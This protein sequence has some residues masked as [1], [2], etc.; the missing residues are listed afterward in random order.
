MGTEVLIGLAVRAAL[1]QAVRIYQQTG[2]EMS[3]ADFVAAADDNLRTAQ[4][5]YGSMKA[6]LA[7]EIERRRAEE[8][9]RT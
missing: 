2:Q 4:T 7:A 3:V 6:D 9:Q 5:A 8:E 1:I